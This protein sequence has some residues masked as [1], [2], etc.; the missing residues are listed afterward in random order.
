M[1]PHF[2]FYLALIGLA[3]MGLS[4]YFRYGD[5]KQLWTV[6]VGLFGVAVFLIN[7]YGPLVFSLPPAQ[8][9]IFF[10]LCQVADVFLAV[11]IIVLLV[12]EFTRE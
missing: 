1:L 5:K 11:A 7:D 4:R 3:Y 2:I 9:G 8:L 12:W 10:R 6:A